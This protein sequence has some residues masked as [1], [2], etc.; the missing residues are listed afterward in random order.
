MNEAAKVGLGRERKYDNGQD[1][2]LG[3]NYLLYGFG[4][5]NF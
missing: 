4:R 5:L 3:V 2:S 1:A